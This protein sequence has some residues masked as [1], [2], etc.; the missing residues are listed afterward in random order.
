M[1]SQSSSISQ[2]NNLIDSHSIDYTNNYVTFKESGKS[3]YYVRGFNLSKDLSKYFTDHYISMSSKSSKANTPTTHSTTN[4]KVKKNINPTAN[5]LHV[6]L[7]HYYSPANGRHYVDDEKFKLFTKKHEEIQQNERLSK[8]IGVQLQIIVEL[9]E[10][11]THVIL[12]S[13][14]FVDM[15]MIHGGVQGITA[16]LKQKVVDTVYALE[17]SNY[18]IQNIWLNKLYINKQRQNIS[19]NIKNVKMYGTAFNYLGYGLEAQQGKIPNACVPEY[20]LKLLNNEDEPNPRKRLKKLTLE[21]IINELGMESITDGCCTEQIKKF[22]DGR[23]ITYYALDFKYKTFDTNNNMN[24][25]SN[26]PR[27]VFMCANNHMYP[28]TDEESRLTIFRS[29]SSIGGKMKKYK[30]Q[31][32][33]ENVT[34]NIGQHSKTFVYLEGMNFYALLDRI[35]QIPRADKD[36]EYF[37]FDFKIVLTVEGTCHSIF[38]NEL[39][40]NNIHGNVRMSKN[41]KIIGFEMDGIVLDENLHYHDIKSTIETLNEEITDDTYKYNYTG[42]HH[43]TLAYQYFT[44][45]YD[46]NIMSCCSPQ[47]YD[48]LISK[49][50]MNAPLLEFYKTDG[51]IAFDKN[52]QY[53]NILC[54]CDSFGWS[55]FSPTD[56]VEPFDGFIDTGMYYVETTN[57]FPLKGNGWYFDDTIEKSLRYKLITIA[58]IKYQVKPSYTLKPNHFESFVNDVY[59]KFEPTYDNGGKTSIN[60]FIGTLGKKHIKSNREYFET[61]YDRVAN[62]IINGEHVSVSGIYDDTYDDAIKSFNLLNIDE[63]EWE[64]MINNADDSEP[65]IYRISYKKELPLYNNALPIHRKI[66]DKALMEMFELDRQIKN[67]NEHCELVGIKTDCLVYKNVTNLPQT[68]DKWGGIKIASVPLIK[69]CTLNQEPKVRTETYKLKKNDW[70][71][72]TWDADNGYTNHKNFKMDINLSS[73]IDDGILFI[74]RAGSG[75]SE[76]LSESQIILAKNNAFKKFMTGCPTHKACK[77]VNG[78]TIHKLFDVNPIDHSYGYKK[79]KELQDTGIKYILLDEISMISEKMWGVLAQIKVIFNFVFVGFGDF[80]QLKQVNEEHIDF[81]N[82]WIVKFIF[83][84]TLCELET[85]HRFKDDEL[86]QDAL[87]CS[88][89]ESIDIT[90]YGNEEHDLALCWTNRAVDAINAKWNNHYAKD[91]HIIVNGA[92]QSKFKLYKGL[93]IIAYRTHGK[94]FYNC[95][96][97]TVTHYNETKLTLTDDNG[98]EIIIDIKLTNHFKPAFALTIYKA[99]GMTINRSYSIYEHGKMRSDMLYVGLT[100]TKQKHF[101]NFCDISIYKPNIGYI[102]SYSFNGKR[103]IGSTIDIKKQKAYHENN[104]SNKF[105]KAISSIGLNNF[106]FEILET[107]NYYERQDLYDIENNYIIKYDSIN[108]GYNCRRCNDEF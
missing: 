1:S 39:H 72:I 12:K 94:T 10:I 62:E 108:K 103:Y 25:N 76:I 56:E 20:L 61:D 78:Q 9:K 69:E 36:D 91:E 105:G 18:E 57:S 104:A 38:Y 34:L 107:V 6:D 66:Y 40:K 70:N 102:Y 22:C 60:G 100:R 92:K 31:Q 30:T 23:K 44:N 106:K 2:L 16:Y 64:T 63:N 68:S 99:Q 49:L 41:N 83:N 37:G 14:V 67:T 50:C 77:I 35:K 81:K 43:H 98:D 29:C 3:Y 86:L 87:K 15:K 82:S 47:L 59:N 75:K 53:T 28:I 84:N 51:D 74:G 95:D 46:T 80:K 73:Y 52:K 17:G 97:Y 24:Y 88:D 85:I 79:V 42:Q 11:D 5:S 33:F 71:K 7:K 19:T 13:H 4:N 55:M 58:D 21:I 48:I 8:P 26:L 96:E 89:G 27:L 101:V 54:N 93:I 65:L 32:K 45:N 90:K